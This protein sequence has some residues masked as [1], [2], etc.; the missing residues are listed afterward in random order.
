MPHTVYSGTQLSDAIQKLDNYFAVKALPQYLHCR[1]MSVEE[2][3]R[4][5]ASRQS[6]MKIHEEYREMRSELNRRKMR[7]KQLEHENEQLQAVKFRC[8]KRLIPLVKLER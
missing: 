8:R 4:W 5:Q 3:L 2:G 7:I 1:V 6:W